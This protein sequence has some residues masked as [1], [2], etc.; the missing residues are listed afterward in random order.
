MRKSEAMEDGN[1]KNTGE[2]I[3]PTNLLPIAN[4]HVYVCQKK[5]M[6]FCITKDFRIS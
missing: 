4:G 1:S 3:F 6:L 5:D 2:T